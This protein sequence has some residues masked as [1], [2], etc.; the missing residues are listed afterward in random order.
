[1][2]KQYFLLTAILFSLNV[3]GQDSCHY[4]NKVYG[5]EYENNSFSGSIIDDDGYLVVGYRNG[6]GTRYINLIKLDEWGDTLW[7]RTLLNNEDFLAFYGGE[8]LIET[9][10]GNLL[11]GYSFRAEE[12]HTSIGLLKFNRNGKIFWNNRTLTNQ[13]NSSV[14]DIGIKH[15]IQTADG[16]FAY[17]GWMTC[18]STRMAVCKTDSIGNVEWIKPYVTEM[19]SS[20]KTIYQ[21]PDGGYVV[22][23]W[24]RREKPEG[25]NT[26]NHNPWVVFLN[27]TGKI[28]KEYEYGGDLRDS[29][30]IIAPYDETHT[31]YLLYYEI[32]TLHYLPTES[33]FAKVDENFNV[34]WEVTG[35]DYYYGWNGEPIILEDGS[36]VTLNM[37]R[38]EDS[39][40]EFILVKYDAMGNVLWRSERYTPDPNKEILI[41]DFDRTADNGFLLTGFEYQPTPQKAWLV[42]F[43]S[44]GNTCKTIGCDSTCNEID[45]F[46]CNSQINDFTINIDSITILKNY[47]LPELSSNNDTS[48]LNYYF[49]KNENGLA[50][51]QE[52]EVLYSEPDTVVFGGI[53]IYEKDTAFIYNTIQQNIAPDSLQNYFIENEICAS[54]TQNTFVLI[55]EDED[56]GINTLS[57]E[58]PLKLLPNPANN[59]LY[60]DV[61]EEG[62]VKIYDL[63]GKLLLTQSIEDDNIVDVSKFAD[64]FY[65]C[66]FTGKRTRVSKSSKLLIN[67]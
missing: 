46:V 66:E 56:T 18:G 63:N 52:N 10:D 8:R 13:C 4:F 39:K 48:Y 64:G 11:I 21:R 28:V 41:R 61:K 31:H 1:M 38:T 9:N 50:F 42:K 7:Y 36:F 62:L 37:D 40:N 60:L 49:T 29:F 22:G 44:L 43:D 30:A 35:T 57:I 45:D 14:M 55:V 54:I 32:D 3:A 51:F 24:I 47:T 59:Q 15:L 26:D 34:I 19:F 17:A 58:N 25:S 16:G 65:M 23:A 6:D 53:N 33:Y 67:R 12:G 2:M 5:P 27:D 20:T